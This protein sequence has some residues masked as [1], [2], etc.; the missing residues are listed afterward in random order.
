MEVVIEVP[1]RL[2]LA[3]VS[4]S[5]GH[6]QL[7]QASLLMRNSSHLKHLDR[8]VLWIPEARESHPRFVA[9]GA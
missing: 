2:W 8:Q 6:R 7:N 1:Q 3:N 9:G 5:L 4:H